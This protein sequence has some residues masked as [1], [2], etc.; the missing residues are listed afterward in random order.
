MIL[1]FISSRRRVAIAG[2]AGTG[3]T[4]LAVEKAKRLAAEGFK[5]LLTCYNRE[6]ANHLSDQLRGYE[7]IVVSNFHSLCLHY[8]TQAEKNPTNKC[9]QDAKRTYPEHDY[10]KV[11]LPVAMS[12][13]LE[14]VKERFEAIVVDEG[15]D[16][17][18]EFWMPL[19]FLLS[20]LETSPFYIFYDTH[21]NLYSNSLNFPITDS[22]FSLNKN[23]RNTLQIH[24]FAYRNY[25][26]PSVV[27]PSLEGE[28]IHS[29]AGIDLERQGRSIQQRVTDL[30]VRGDVKANQI[31]VLVGDS[32]VKDACYRV[33][34][35]LPLPH[36]SKW[37]FEGGFQEGN[38]LVETV[39]RFKGLEAEV[40]FIWT[41]PLQGSGDY[42]EVLYVG[43]SRA[44]SDLTFVGT[45]D[46]IIQLGL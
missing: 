36:G 11:Q 46:E 15:Q 40:V 38:V 41:L 6:L 23:C 8:V 34:K 32:L 16:F 37:N 5:T 3:K 1:D 42:T 25:R 22:P 30:I 27:G 9:L 21:Q 7:N 45:K 29:I 14:F 17:G 28:T 20:D 19:E 33:M 24:D 18:D 13:A 35:A 44:C 43:A 4:V 31:V 39:K 2:G 10:W 12:F 26:G